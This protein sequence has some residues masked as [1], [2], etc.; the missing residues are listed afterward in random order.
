MES[1]DRPL[2]PLISSLVDAAHESHSDKKLQHPKTQ[3]YAMFEWQ[4]QEAAAERQEQVRSR[5][6]TEDNGSLGSLG[7]S[8]RSGPR[9]RRMTDTNTSF[10]G[11][12]SMGQRMSSQGNLS[13]FDLD[14]GG[15]PTCN[16]EV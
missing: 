14:E 5:R 16:L 7:A 11:G 8:N 1:I 6:Q 2:A 4:L 13:N 10:Q 12:G 3:Q 15:P 9:G